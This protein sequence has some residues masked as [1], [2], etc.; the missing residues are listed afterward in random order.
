M[1]L[2][3]IQK[4]VKAKQEIEIKTEFGTY[5]GVPR[6]SWVDRTVTLKQANGCKSVIE[7]DDIP[8]L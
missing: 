3:D 5:R 7:F 1:N 2:T 6:I 4:A 8:G